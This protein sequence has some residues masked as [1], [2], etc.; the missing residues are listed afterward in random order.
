MT[1]SHGLGRRHSP[2]VRDHQYLL[3]KPERR[4]SVISKIWDCTDPVLDQGQTPMCVGYGTTNWL[5]A[6]PVL[7]PTI[8]PVAMYHAAQRNDEWPGENYEGTSVRGAMKALKTIG[9]VSVYNWTFDI[10]TTINYVLEKGPMV[11]GTNWYNNMFTPDANFNLSV[12]GN[13]AGGHCYVLI[14]A[15]QTHKNRS[16]ARGAFRILN[17]WGP[18]WGDHGRAWVSFSSMGRLISERYSGECAVATEILE[19]VINF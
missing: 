4:S 9:A 13:N 1:T 11:V 10:E 17:S 8:D 2:D 6:A 18:T 14:G 3:S 7:N 5:R 12:S 16:G 15:D 19:K